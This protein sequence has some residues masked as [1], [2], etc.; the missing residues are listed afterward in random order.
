ML[1]ISLRTYTVAEPLRFTRH[2]VRLNELNLF[3]YAGSLFLSHDFRFKTKI[4][5]DNDVNEKVTVTVT[6]N[7]EIICMSHLNT[8]PKF[9]ETSPVKLYPRFNYK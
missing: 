3:I 8:N 1:F 5:F 9:G 2:T 6:M 7:L 4:I